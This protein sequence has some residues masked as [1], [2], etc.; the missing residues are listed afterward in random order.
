MTGFEAMFMII[1]LIFL[2]AKTLLVVAIVGAVLWA[3]V[4]FASLIFKFIWY[5]AL[6]VLSFA[7]L[8]WLL[9]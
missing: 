4:T 9:V 2:L 1:G 7:G 6:T 3:I 5:G 8:I